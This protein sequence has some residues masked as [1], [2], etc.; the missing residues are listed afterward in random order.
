MVFIRKG[1][2]NWGGVF[3][4]LIEFWNIINTD[5]FININRSSNAAFP[6]FIVVHLPVQV[7][8]M[9]KL[10]LATCCTMIIIYLQRLHVSDTEHDHLQGA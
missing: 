2:R 3:Y 6:A 1:T 4:F 7:P 10:S 5:G 9:N 8:S